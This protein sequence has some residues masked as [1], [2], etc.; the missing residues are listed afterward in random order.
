MLSE[1]DVYVSIFRSQEKSEYIVE[2]TAS[3][4][5][6]YTFIYIYKFALS[7]TKSLDLL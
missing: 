7:N 3:L 4:Q 6:K 5:L 2:L 1:Y